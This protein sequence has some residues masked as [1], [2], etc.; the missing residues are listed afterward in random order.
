MHIFCSSKW[1]W[2]FLWLKFGQ[3]EMEKIN[4]IY[5]HTYIIS[6]PLSLFSTGLEGIGVFCDFINHMV[7]YL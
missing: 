7:K 3:S 5:T 2:N 4:Y 1:L 6:Y